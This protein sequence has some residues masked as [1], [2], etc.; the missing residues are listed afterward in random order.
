MTVDTRFAPQH[1]EGPERGPLVDASHGLELPH[2][3]PRYSAPITVLAMLFI[4]TA[5]GLFAGIRM[6]VPV[7]D[8]VEAADQS[9]ELVVSRTLALDDALHTL[10][11][12]ERAFYEMTLGG[13]ADDLEDAIRWYDE[14]AEVA[15]DPLPGLYALILKAEAGGIGTI[16]PTL[17]QWAQDKDPLVTFALLLRA[18]YGSTDVAPPVAQD[19]QAITAEEVPD[20]WF[21]TTLALALAQR[22]GDREAVA[23]LEEAR[24]ARGQPL[25]WRL[26]AL[27][28]VQVAMILVGSLA[29][30]LLGWQ[31]RRTGSIAVAHAPLPPPWRGRVGVAVLA[32]G[33][34]LGMGWLLVLFSLGVEDPVLRIL[35]VPL[36]VVPVLVLASQSLLQPNGLGLRDGFGLAIDPE[37]RG[38][39]LLAIGA[40]TGVGLLGEVGLGLIADWTES[41][42]HWTEW[43]DDDLVSGDLAVTGTA[44]VVYVIV[45]PVTEELVFRGL[46]FGTLRRRL[47][48]GVA[49]LVSA[50]VFAVLHGYGMF[51]LVSVLYSGVIWAVAY[52]MTGSLVPGM[53]AHMLNNL[54]VTASVLL[55]LRF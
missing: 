37:R 2:A 34:A 18:A 45:A 36:A 29:A 9:L 8:R 10:P 26:R 25:L 19:L 48:L 50:S 32:R 47:R 20:G 55:F 7:L 30:L 17:E 23:R 24:L 33:G 11:D 15:V 42:S 54:I 13:T 35:S 40:L 44:L 41:T 51:G 43:Y 6:A 27:V 4:L 28:G 16:Q 3:G 52:E 39:L 49:A 31:Y 46:L 1:P 53:V 12:W 5:I 38:T 22:S 21:Y 14:L